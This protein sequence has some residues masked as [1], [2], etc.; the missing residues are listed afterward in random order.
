M[1]EASWSQR[2]TSPAM[3]PVPTSWFCQC[4]ALLPGPFQPQS[5]V[6]AMARR[7]PDFE[8]NQNTFRVADHVTWGTLSSREGWTLHLL[9]DATGIPEHLRRA[10]PPHPLIDEA[11]T[12][13]SVFVVEA[14]RRQ[15]TPLEPVATMCRM[16]WTFLDVG[17][18]GIT[19]PM[20]LRT[21]TREQMLKLDPSRLAPGDV[22]YFVA[23][24]AGAGQWRS[25][26]MGQLG[27]PEVGCAVA[28][29][30]DEEAADTQIMSMMS[31]L[32]EREGPLPVGDT[33]E[34]EHRLWKVSPESDED[35]QL[36]QRLR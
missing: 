11:R 31:Y 25:A 17:A 29:E 22:P 2:R 32:V 6:E 19:F 23:V 5:W 34:L 15:L 36:F 7:M 10:I 9:L 21:W 14:P 3:D 1:H 30:E 4:I 13:A 33:V 28:T 24:E 18:T 20:G 26:G 35:L 12:A 16:A 8:V 27:L